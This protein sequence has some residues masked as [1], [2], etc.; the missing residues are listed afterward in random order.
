MKNKKKKIILFLIWVLAGLLAYFGYNIYT[1]IVP[2][3]PMATKVNERFGLMLIVVAIL[4]VIFSHWIVSKLM[5]FATAILVILAI[6]LEP[7]LHYF[8]IPHT[9]G[10]WIPYLAEGAVLSA[11]IAY[12]K[13][14]KMKIDDFLENLKENSQRQE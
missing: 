4:M 2:F 6:L 9:E 14:I 8:G 11:L 10:L 3:N 12:W 7:I 1:E 13:N 5:R